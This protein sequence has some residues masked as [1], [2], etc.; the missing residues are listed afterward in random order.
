MRLLTP[1]LSI[2]LVLIS[3][4]LLLPHSTE[5]IPAVIQIMFT[6]RIQ[7]FYASKNIFIGLMLPYCLTMF[8]DTH[9]L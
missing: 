8:L 4:V 2:Y 9:I 5:D 1:A 3:C 6:D 7:K